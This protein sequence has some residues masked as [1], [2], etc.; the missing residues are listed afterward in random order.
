MT[1][2]TSS[3]PTHKPS[4]SQWIDPRSFDILDRRITRMEVTINKIFVMVGDIVKHS[5]KEIR[6]RNEKRTEP[7]ANRIPNGFKEPD[8]PLDDVK[9]IYLF[10]KM[11]KKKEI[12]SYL[13]EQEKE[14]CAPSKSTNNVVMTAYLKRFI[15]LKVRHEVALKDPKGQ[16][17]VVLHRDFKRVYD[18]LIDVMKHGYLAYGERI[19]STEIKTVL[20]TV[21]GRTNQMLEEK[22]RR[23]YK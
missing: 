11:L 10:N 17:D 2:R 15:S 18:F 19:K 4:T 7:T 16:K 9:S 3:R 1:D 20:R 21:W 12:H 13:L 5:N 6:S 14:Y 22:N 23:N 8:L